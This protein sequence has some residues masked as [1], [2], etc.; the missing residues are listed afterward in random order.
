[1]SRRSNRF[2]SMNALSGFVTPSSAF[3]CIGGHILSL[4]KVNG[5]HV[6][7]TMRIPRNMRTI[8][9][10]TVIPQNTDM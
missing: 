1:M 9:R 3:I 7:S 4:N 10:L 5:T 2:A 6:N 8:S